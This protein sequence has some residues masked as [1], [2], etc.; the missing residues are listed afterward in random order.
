M[1]HDAVPAASV[2]NALYERSGA[3][4]GLP[5]YHTSRLMPVRFA[6]GLPAS[7]TS[8]SRIVIVEKLFAVAARPFIVTGE[9]CG[10]ALEIVA[11]TGPPPPAD[12]RRIT[13]P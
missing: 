11:S 12:A 5:A 9:A 6:T 8:T 2:V 4:T 13:A 1:F 10:L 3:P 7:F